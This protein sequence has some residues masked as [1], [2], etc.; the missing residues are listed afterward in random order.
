MGIAYGVVQEDSTFSLMA[1]FEVDGAVGVQANITGVTIK[2]WDIQDF[3]TA[4]L[5]ATPT[6]ASVVYDTLQTDGRWDVDGAG[7]NFRYDV[8][9]NVCVRASSRYRFEAVLTTSGGK[10]P[11]LAW[12]VICL[13]PTLTRHG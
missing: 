5:D 8:A 9:D 7:Y 10:L 1:R 3:D 4:V 13:S 2:A 11:P 6:V 12:E